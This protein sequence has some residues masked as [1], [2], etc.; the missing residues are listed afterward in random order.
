M[1]SKVFG[2]GRRGLESNFRARVEGRRRTQRK[3]RTLL[4]IVEKSDLLLLL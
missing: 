2:N 3:A 1:R 4:M